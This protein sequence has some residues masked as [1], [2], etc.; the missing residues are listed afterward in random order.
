[1]L[2]KGNK[3]VTPIIKI[4]KGHDPV[5]STLDVTPTTSAQT[6]TAP[7][8]TDGYSPVKVAP[9]TSAIDENIVASNIRKNVEI[10]GVQ[11]NVIEANNT[12]TVITE[13]GTYT[14]S[15]TYT[16]FGSVEVNVAGLQ[17]TGTINITENG[18]YTV[19]TYEKAFVNVGNGNGI[20]EQIMAD[21]VAGNN[22]VDITALQL[23]ET[24]IAA[25]LDI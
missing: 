12:N 25:F 8:G 10:L 7:S 5:I 21:V 9:V 6:I 1:M 17:P 3:K 13:N 22:P 19:S 2:Y 16:G 14:P 11:G 20:L 18:T 4:V 23:A 15:S 24:Q